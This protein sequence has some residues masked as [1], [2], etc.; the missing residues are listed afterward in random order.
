MT[1]IK[2]AN[3]YVETDDST[4][5][6]VK[7]MGKGTFRVVQIADLPIGEDE[8]RYFVGVKDVNVLEMADEK[9]HE[10]LSGYYDQEERE[11]IISEIRKGGETEKNY[12]MQITAEA[13][14][15]NSLIYPD[16]TPDMDFEMAKTALQN[17]I[18]TDHMGKPISEKIIWV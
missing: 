5:Q 12:A 15:E 10:E 14:F 2:L 1:D 17:F 13:V 7:N 11:R 4:Y 18:L 9:I 6:F 3:G 8:K 16:L